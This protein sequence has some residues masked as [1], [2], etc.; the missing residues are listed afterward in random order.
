[1]LTNLQIENVALI[2]KT[3]IH[4]QP[5][6]NI[7]SGETGAGK[8]MVI[9]SLH[10]ALGERVSRDF[11][12][13]GAEQAQVS[14]LFIIE[15]K[16]FA[17]RLGKL[18]IEIL[19]DGAL[20]LSRSMNGSGKTV[21]RINGR[22]VTLGMLR[23]ATEGLMDFHGQHSHQSLLNPARH[24][25]L[26]D[27]LCQNQ[28]SPVLSAYQESYEAYCRWDKEYEALLDTGG[29]LEREKDFLQYQAEEIRQANLSEEYN[30]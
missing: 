5:G 14:A 17:D 28:L 21:C 23:E 26:L 2:E 24:I 10:F 20:L 16:E 30:I 27:K 15:E 12:R 19:E 13:Q 8:S 25:L 11:L 18:G 3:E 7:L 9:D 4:F 22:V 6:L 29:T 1:M